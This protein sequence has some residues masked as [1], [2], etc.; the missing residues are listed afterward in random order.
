MRRINSVL[1]L[2]YNYPPDIG[3]IE[4][5]ISQYIKN[6][7]LRGI[8][9]TTIVLRSRI[10]EARIVSSSGPRVIICPGH[11]RYLRSN[12]SLVIRE[13]ISRRVSVVHVFSGGNT[14]L[15]ISCLLLARLSNIPSVLSFFGPEGVIF[16]TIAGRAV[17]DISASV[18][19]GIAT[20]TEPMKLLVPERFQ[21]KTHVLLGG[22]D[23]EAS[24]NSHS[25]FHQKKSQKVLYVGRLI[26]RKGAKDLLQAFSKVKYSLPNARLVIVGDGPE[27]EEL[28]QMSKE[29]KLADYVEFKGTLRG[30]DLSQEYENCDLFV[31]P[32]KYVPGDQIEGLGLVLIEA[33]MHA[34]ALVGT[35][36]GGIPT[37]IKHGVN[38]LLVPEAD[39]DD[40][41]IAIS[42]LLQ[43][44]NIRLA[45]GKKAFELAER[46]YTWG[47]ATDRLLRI[48]QTV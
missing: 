11:L 7:T 2:T 23:L 5:R 32:S 37:V 41:A 15:G 33:S 42:K 39:P 31:M 14:L 22:A 28:I 4:T 40:L 13:T 10:L 45:M 43:D 36:H 17:F 20:N 30:K 6:L 12:L 1:F 34:K 8:D 27:K 29:L 16:P 24:D 3:G 21:K 26:E 46:D 25:E 48:Y 9:V 35:N 38:G 18:A 47:A 19:S 44:D